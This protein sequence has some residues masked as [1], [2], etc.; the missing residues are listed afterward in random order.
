VFADPHIRLLHVAD[1][2]SP[3]PAGT[4]SEG[5]SDGED[6]AKENVPPPRKKVLSKSLG[7]VDMKPPAS[8]PLSVSAT[9][10]VKTHTRQ[11]SNSSNAT[12]RQ[13]TVLAS[14]TGPA[15]SPTEKAM[16]KRVMAS[17]ADDVAGGSD[18]D[19]TSDE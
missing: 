7:D 3:S 13:S 17:E 8:V 6:S 11:I 16:R 5:E 9:A 14:L 2:H 10:A 4:N 15:S 19:D 1:R 12:P 18:D